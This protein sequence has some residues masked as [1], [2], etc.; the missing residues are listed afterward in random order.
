MRTLNKI[1]SAMYA[2]EYLID[3][4]MKISV[5]LA[6][7][8]EFPTNA[9]ISEMMGYFNSILS[10]I[11]DTPSRTISDL[12]QQIGERKLVLPQDYVE[13]A[14]KLSSQMPIIYKLACYRVI[15]VEYE[16]LE[17]CIEKVFVAW[18]KNGLSLKNSSVEDARIYIDRLRNQLMP[19]RF[20]REDY[21][22]NDWLLRE[23]DNLYSV[24]IRDD[25]DMSVRE[26]EV[27]NILIVVK[28]NC[29]VD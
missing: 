23:L 20:G 17:Q 18:N 5:S 27:K 26:Q 3:K 9:D 6:V 22:M 12:R 8:R 19:P 14:Q 13:A 29:N 10:E 11:G 15:Q 7:N 28:K 2:S 25:G 21:R 16:K 24:L 4:I 1:Y